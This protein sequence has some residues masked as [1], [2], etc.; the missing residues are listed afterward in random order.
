MLVKHGEHN[1]GVVNRGLRCWIN[2]VDLDQPV[3]LHTM[4]VKCFDKALNCLEA[5]SFRDAAVNFSELVVKNKTSLAFEGLTGDCRLMLDD[6]SIIGTKL[7]N[8][9]RVV[10]SLPRHCFH[11]ISE[12]H[13]FGC[14]FWLSDGGKPVRE[15]RVGKVIRLLSVNRYFYIVLSEV[16]NHRIELLFSNSG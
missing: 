13:S 9:L 2:A 1:V 6:T 15:N 10:L 5:C 11:W 8:D 12:K 14:I 16:V 7:S 3:W 4:L